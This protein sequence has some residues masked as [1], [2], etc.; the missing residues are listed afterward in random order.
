M[1]NKCDTPSNVL[2]VTYNIPLSPDKKE[3][4]AICV[5]A[6]DFPTEDLSL[7]LVE[8]LD[9]TRVMGAAKVFFYD[10]Q[11]PQKVRKILE[12]YQ[13]KG[14]ISVTPVTLPGDNHDIVVI[15]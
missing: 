12:V 6:L 11:V 8:W 15:V 7:R 14:L 9:M 13:R 3:D 10:M 1:E 2:R 4:I 5:K